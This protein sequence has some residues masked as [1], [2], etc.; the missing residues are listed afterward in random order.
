MFGPGLYTSMCGGLE[1]RGKLRIYPQQEPG[2]NPN[3]LPTGHGK[4]DMIVG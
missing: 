2:N 3:H 1:V 4:T